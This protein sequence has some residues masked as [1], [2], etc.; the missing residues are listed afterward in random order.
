MTKHAHAKWWLEL[1]IEI[2]S[3]AANTAAF[4][5]ATRERNLR[6]AEQLKASRDA[7]CRDEQRVPFPQAVEL[8]L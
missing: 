6:Q 7:L 2:A 5:A 8:D 4:D 1:G 3:R